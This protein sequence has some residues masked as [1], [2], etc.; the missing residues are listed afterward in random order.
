MDIVSEWVHAT[1]D[2]NLR[3]IRR[4][5]L[6]KPSTCTSVYFDEVLTEPSAPRGTWFNANNYRGQPIDMTI[7]PEN[8]D[9]SVKNVPGL[10]V[11]VP[12]LL[13]LGVPDDKAPTWQLFRLPPKKTKYLQVK[14]VMILE[15]DPRYDWVQQHLEIVAG[16]RDEYVQLS[17]DSLSGQMIWSALDARDLVMIGVF[18]VTPSVYDEEGTTGIPFHLFR[19]YRMRKRPSPQPTERRS[20]GVLVP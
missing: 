6:L 1:S 20:Q 11:S 4:D 14:Y 2:H 5:G 19:T 8:L 16:N 7:Y 10:A 12:A 18:Y 13:N 3:L 9:S 15:N 17:F